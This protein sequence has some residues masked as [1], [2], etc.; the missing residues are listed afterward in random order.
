MAHTTLVPQPLEKSNE[1]YDN[2]T[3]SKEFG[4]TPGST[5]SSPTTPKASPTSTPNRL[6]MQDII[7]ASL[8]KYSTCQKYVLL[9][10]LERSLCREKHNL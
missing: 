5:K 9:D 10:M 4:T 7:N 2:H 6:T 3:I 1:K 8:H